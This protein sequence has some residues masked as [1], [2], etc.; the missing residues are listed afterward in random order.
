MD[1]KLRNA[2]DARSIE[3]L[4]PSNS[5]N[6]ASFRM[7]SS[8]KSLPIRSSLLL[9][10][11]QV[12][13]ISICYVEDIIFVEGFQH[14]IHSM[15]FHH[16]VWYCCL[17][18][19]SKRFTRSPSHLRSDINSWLVTRWHRERVEAQVLEAFSFEGTRPSNMIF[20]D[21]SLSNNL[22]LALCARTEHP[23]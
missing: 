6:R 14:V 3:I 13:Y 8:S 16:T 4:A 1:C 18:A 7:R 2:R 9:T 23:V 22:I 12:I 5:G 19:L 10:S 15:L 20:T 11:M 17:Y 21:F